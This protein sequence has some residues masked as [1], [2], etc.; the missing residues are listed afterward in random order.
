VSMMRTEKSGMDNLL[1]FDR[2]NETTEQVRRA[3]DCFGEDGS[4]D[5]GWERALSRG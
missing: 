3:A 1:F 5:Q 4:I 2:L